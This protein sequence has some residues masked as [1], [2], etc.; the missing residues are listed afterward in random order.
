MKINPIIKIG[1]YDNIVQDSNH[2]LNDDLVVINYDLVSIFSKYSNFFENFDKD[3]ISELYTLITNDIDLILNNL[4]QIPTVVFNTFSG[5]GIYVNS[6]IPSKA[7]IFANKLNEYL[8]S[9][10][11]TNLNILDINVAMAKVGIENSYDA[12]MFYVSKTLYTISFWKEYV[13]ELSSVIFKSTGRLKKAIIFDCDNTLWKGILGEDGMGSIDMSAES[14]FG[15]IFNRIQQIAVWLSK[16]GVIV[17]LCSKNNSDDVDKVLFEHPDMI[18]KKEHIVI[19]KVNWDDKATNLR[20]ISEEL[21]IGLDS[22]VFVDDSSFEI[23]L[24]RE[25]IPEILSHQVPIKLEEFPSQLLSVIQRN[26]YLSGNKDDLDKTKQY[27]AQSIRED[28]KSRHKSI[29]D[30]LFSIGIEI[31]INENDSSQIPRIAQLTQKT[32]Q[33]NLTTKRYTENQIKEFIDDKIHRIFS[34]KVKDKFG[35][36]G[37]TAIVIINEKHPIANI[38]T[39]ILSCR[40]MGRN[41]EKAIMNYIVDYYSNL[42][43]NEIFST[44]FPT[45]KNKPVLEMYEDFGF[46]ILNEDEGKKYYKVKMSEYAHQKVNYVKINNHG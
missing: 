13:Y 35:E 34:I 20:S 10:K 37:L 44:Y 21:N 7:S 32:N 31:S 27:K 4:R 19:S 3:E 25:Q 12:R 39:F 22:I 45:V 38:D 11:E 36:S 43:F 14:N 6:V 1:N 40:I 24:V 30:Y 5:F 23:N 16:Q 9:R 17:G 42:G 33:F 28:E 46:E 15:Q 2:C 18:L 8:F 29:E 41:I 26:F